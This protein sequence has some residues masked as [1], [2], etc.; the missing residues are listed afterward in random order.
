MTTESADYDSPW[1]EALEQW[2]PEC[3]ALLFP[4][5]YRE[6]D[7]GVPYIFMDKELQKVVRDGKLGRRYAD[8]LV[9]VTTLDGTATWVLIHIEVQGDSET[10]FSHRMYTYNYRLYD[11]YQIDIVSL[12]V[13]ADD[14]RS[15]RPGGFR[16][17]RWGCETE[18]RFPAVKL[19][20][21]AKDLPALEA[22]DNPFAIVVLAQLNAILQRDG[23]QR[24]NA[25]LQLIRM[26]YHRGYDKQQILELFRVIDWILQLPPELEL[27]LEQDISRFE[28]EQK[29][30]YI[31]S[32]ERIGEQRGEQRGHRQG[33]SGLLHSLLQAKF[34]DAYSQAHREQVDQADSEAIAAWSLRILTAETI[35]DVFQD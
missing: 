5:I 28:E 4:D 6:I 21:W 8:K 34:R 12:A 15:F 33:Q 30:P 3:M 25:K 2:F 29:M 22:N 19:L 1:K 32:I 26:L 31:T 24:K 35:E 11:R 10:G 18:F 7:W 13:L 20:D 16:R 17:A 9:K 27:Q 23:Q 14:T